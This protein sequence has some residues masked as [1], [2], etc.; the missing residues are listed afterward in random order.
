M[1]TRIEVPDVEKLTGTS[2]GA[3]AIDL[4]IAV[5]NEII[6]DRLENKGLTDKQLERLE[7]FLAAHLVIANRERQAVSES[8]DPASIQYSDIFGEGLKS[9]TYGQTVLQLD[10]TGTLQHLDKKTINLKAVKE[11]H[12]FRYSNRTNV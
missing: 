2:V 11:E 12:E 10:S 5:A 6:T 9:T 8:V 3:L 1:A 7:L 4:Y